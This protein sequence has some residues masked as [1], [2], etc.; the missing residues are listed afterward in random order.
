MA[1]RLSVMAGGFDVSRAV[2]AGIGDRWRAREFVAEFAAAWTRPLA[3]GDGCSE[4]VLRAAEDRLG[5]RIPAA[6]RAAYLLFGG[7]RDLTACQDPLL[8]PDRLRMDH[9]AQ[10]IVFRSENQ[11]CAEWGVAA[12]GWNAEDPP[13]YVRQL[14]GGRPWEPFLGRMSLACAEMVLTEVLL[15]SKF[16]DMCDLPGELI[17]AAESAYR[18]VALPEYPLWAE[19]AVTIRW[20]AAPGKLLRMDGRGPYCWLSAAGQTRTDLESIYKTIPGPWATG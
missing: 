15:G 6:L 12:T 8:P 13:V 19:P 11:R 4:D 14:P 16:M 7:R 10:V 3:P 1:A 2:G 17:G 9:A 5:V 18:Q 20:F